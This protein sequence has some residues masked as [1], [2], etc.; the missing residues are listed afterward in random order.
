MKRIIDL[1]DNNSSRSISSPFLLSL[2]I[3]ESKSLEND[4]GAV[5]WDAGL[6]LIKYLARLKSQGCTT[7]NNPSIP[8]GVT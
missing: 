2:I 3:E 5:L 4:A 6:V 7:T 1:I 8:N